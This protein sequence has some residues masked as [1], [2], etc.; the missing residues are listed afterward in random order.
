VLAVFGAGLTVEGGEMLEAFDDLGSE[1]EHLGPLRI[2]LV[3]QALGQPGGAARVPS[4]RLHRSE[5]VGVAWRR[6]ALEGAGG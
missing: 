2:K 4:K 3:R 1:P 6:Q 5:V